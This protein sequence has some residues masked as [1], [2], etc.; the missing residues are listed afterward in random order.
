MQL[1]LF[2]TRFVASHL[3]AL[4]SI[5][6]GNSL[7]HSF[8]RYWVIEITFNCF[9]NFP[10]FHIFDDC[11]LFKRKV[12]LLLPR[13]E[14]ESN[15]F[16]FI[17]A[18]VLL[19]FATDRNIL[20]ECTIMWRVS[21]DEAKLCACVDVTWIWCLWNW[22]TSTLKRLCRMEESS[23]LAQCKRISP[24]FHI[25]LFDECWT[26]AFE[27]RKLIHTIE[28][29]SFDNRKHLFSWTCG[30]FFCSRWGLVLGFWRRLTVVASLRPLT[31]TLTLNRCHNSQVW[32]ALLNQILSRCTIAANKSSSDVN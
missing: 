29:N 27:R 20:I 23:F 8:S 16:F 22:L 5:P 1:L 13:T 15:V 14:I 26:R 25:V 6:K 10:T 17:L 7:R 2:L 18:P 19:N 11:L 31:F 24:R 4:K 32:D 3:N 12:A 9:I 30:I 28:K 21:L